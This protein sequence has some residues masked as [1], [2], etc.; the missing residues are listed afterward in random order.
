MMRLNVIRTA[1]INIE[2]HAMNFFFQIL[3]QKLFPPL[4]EKK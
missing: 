4:T 1:K 2:I 3:N